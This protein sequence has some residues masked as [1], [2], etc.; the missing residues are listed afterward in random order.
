MSKLLERGVG[1]LND[2]D[3]TVK[4]LGTRIGLALDGI[5]TAAECG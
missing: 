4:Q 2:A 5:T 3:V 1:L